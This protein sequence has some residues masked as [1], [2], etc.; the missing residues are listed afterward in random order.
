[1]GVTEIDK[2]MKHSR[3]DLPSFQREV[4]TSMREFRFTDKPE[5]TY[6]GANDLICGRHEYVFT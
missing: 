6:K 2:N 1:M 3:Q 5:A 4:Q